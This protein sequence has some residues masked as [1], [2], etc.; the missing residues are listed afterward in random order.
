[1]PPT[2]EV[3]IKELF[4]KLDRKLDA[5][6]SRLDTISK[7]VVDL[8][9]GQARLEEKIDGMDKNF[10]KRLDYQEFISR[11]VLIG[12]LLALFGGLAKLFGFGGNP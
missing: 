3:D 7:D 6:N 10:S 5:V 2:I 12:L 4:D 9:V 1:M 8:K 11:G